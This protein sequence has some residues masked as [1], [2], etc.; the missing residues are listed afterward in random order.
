MYKNNGG[1]FPTGRVRD[2]IDGAKEVAAHGSRDMPV[3]E[4]FFRRLGEDNVTY[5]VATWQVTSKTL[6]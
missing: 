3:W 5:R 4:T 2:Y 1:K 6:Q